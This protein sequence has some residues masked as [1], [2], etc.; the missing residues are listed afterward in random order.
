M[1]GDAKWLR[2]SKGKLTD[3]QKAKFPHLSEY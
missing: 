2:L 3:A 1:T